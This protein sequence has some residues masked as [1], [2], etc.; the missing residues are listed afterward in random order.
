VS[1]LSDIQPWSDV[2]DAARRTAADSH[3]VVNKL[4]VHQPQQT[5][6]PEKLKPPMTK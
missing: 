3:D 2:M 5:F 6:C 4:S 1:I